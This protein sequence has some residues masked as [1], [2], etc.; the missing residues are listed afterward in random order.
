[1]ESV[2]T[3]LNED[4]NVIQNIAVNNSMDV[5]PIVTHE[6]EPSINVGDNNL[7]TPNN[8]AQDFADE[9][10]EQYS[11]HKNK[12]KPAP[13]EI[14]DLMKL[15][16]DMLERGEDIPDSFIQ[17]F[18][19]QMN[20]ANDFDVQSLISQ[21]SFAS[22][23]NGI[24]AVLESKK[25]RQRDQQF[26]A[27]NAYVVPNISQ[28]PE[29]SE[30]PETPVPPETPVVPETPV[31]PDMPDMPD[32]PDIPQASDEEL[33]N[34][35]MQTEHGD[36]PDVHQDIPLPDM[37]GNPAATNQQSNEVAEDVVRSAKENEARQIASDEAKESKRSAAAKVQHK[38]DNAEAARPS[39]NNEPKPTTDVKDAIDTAEPQSAPMPNQQVKS[40][41]RPLLSSLATPFAA[42]MSLGKKKE[43]TP[44]LDKTDFTQQM[45]RNK[46]NDFKKLCEDQNSRMS[47][48]KSHTQ[49][50][51]KALTD[52]DGAFAKLQEQVVGFKKQTSI[53]N[54]AYQNLLKIAPKESMSEVKVLGQEFKDELKRQKD[55]VNTMLK[56]S[57]P[58]AIGKLLKGAWATL[59]KHIDSIMNSGPLEGDVQLASQPV[60]EL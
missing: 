12:V 8:D 25:N 31:I 19:A 44:H 3:N 37:G 36:Y 51:L 28:T 6:D 43:A 49:N 33:M 39:S 30:I 10:F 58:S 11:T 45:F 41:F 29:F 20:V 2:T 53:L 16:N 14:Q 23:F 22:Q 26:N 40:I 48:M 15:M 57:K 1:M 60:Q 46:F 38:D 27:S 4:L 9:I 54:K 13:T 24:S 52:P 59:S 47:D 17:E 56:D 42:M 35:M 50:S 5:K 34:N 21:F 7:T 55:D 32:M 18:E